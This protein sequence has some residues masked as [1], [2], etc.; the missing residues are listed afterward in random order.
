[1]RSLAELACE[2]IAIQDACNP[3]GVSNAYAVALADLRKAL[4]RQCLPSDT[5]AL[6]LHPI[7][8]LWASKIHDLAGMGLSN[9]DSYSIAYEECKKLAEGK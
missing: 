1:M 7:N 5:K 4:D 6:C 2:A 8:G 3:L 9:T